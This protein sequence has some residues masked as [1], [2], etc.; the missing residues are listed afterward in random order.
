MLQKSTKQTP[1]EIL[2]KGIEIELEKNND[3]NEATE[4]S[5]ENLLDSSD[6]YNSVA[7]TDELRD[8]NKEDQLRNIE[9]PSDDHDL[10]A[11]E[12]LKVTENLIKGVNL[13]Q[14][15]KSVSFIESISDYAEFSKDVLY[16]HY[17]IIKHNIKKAIALSNNEP[18]FY[19][20][21][22]MLK[23]YLNSLGINE[24]GSSLYMSTDGVVE[25]E[26][27]IADKPFSVED[28]KKI[29]TYKGK[30]FYL[31]NKLKLLGEGSSRIVFKIDNKKVIKLA[32]NSKGLGQNFLEAE[33]GTDKYYADAVAQVFDFDPDFIWIIS[34]YASK[35]SEEKFKEIE[36]YS[37]RTFGVFLTSEKY[38]QEW[39]QAVTPEEYEAFQNSKSPNSFAKVIKQLMDDA[40][41]PVGDLVARSSYGIS[42]RNGKPAVILIDYGLDDNVYK[43]YYSKIKEYVIREMRMYLK[44]SEPVFE[45]KMTYMPNSTSVE[46]KRNCK[47]AGKSDGTSDACNQGDIS[48]L[49]LRPIRE[50]SD[51]EYKKWKRENVTY[52]G[53]SD[54]AVN[55]ENNGMA[56]LGRGL[57]SVPASNKSMARKYGKLVMLVNAK[58]KNPKVFNTL[59]D[60][61]IWFQN[62]IVFPISKAKGKTYPDSRDVNS[63]SE[64]MMK[65]GYDGVIIKGREMVNYKPE[66]VRY[67]YNERQLEMYY[68]HY[69]APNSNNINEAI[70]INDINDLPF[71]QEIENL[72][73]KLYSVGGAVRDEF[74]GKDS[75]DLDVLITGIS[76]E[77][78]EKLL[79]KYGRVNAVG[80]SFGILKF[81]PEGS[82]E[83]IDIAIP[84]TERATGK[85]GHKGFEIASDHSLPIEKDLERRDFTINAIAKSAS[86]DI[87]DPYGGQEDLKNKIIRVVNPK[88]FS[89]DPLR[90]LRAVQFAA[91]FEGFMIEE[92]T[93]ELIKQNAHRIK[94]I[95]AERILTELDKIVKKGDV[96]YGADLLR[97]TGLYEQIFGAKSPEGFE[98]HWDL[99]AWNEVKTMGEYIY[100]LASPV[101]E[102]PA[103]FYKNILKGD[104]STYKEI[105]A[106]QTGFN[107]VTNNP[108]K[109]RIVAHNMY[110]I[111]PASLNSKIL[112][113][114]L[115]MATEELKTGKYP[116]SYK[117]LV[118]TG[119][120]LLN[121]GMSGKKLGDALKSMLISVYSDKVKNNKNDLLNIIN[122]T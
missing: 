14:I 58:P 13:S 92:K 94:E 23:N 67:F 83:E 109:N 88:A 100:L 65:L 26:N 85:G 50:N 76:L 1:K 24:N 119:N 61:E 74:L 28:L 117:D 11:I 45:R 32:K 19:E 106:L 105:L 111:Y 33:I 90:M 57:Y 48:N 21:L 53:I 18:M 44:D 113:K 102:N 98:D 107:N 15:K 89:D 115:L 49:K 25:N 78:L 54:N 93:M 4:L 72:G 69:V 22:M 29:K 47:L 63:I 95:P 80:K 27:K 5:L 73:G 39:K 2:L 10:W 79:S 51:L 66:N 68:D 81:K 46:V 103:E 118:I 75:K 101:Q 87:V 82:S 30:I 52:R 97:E 77:N 84:R 35:I 91:R 99:N 116:K 34:E 104:I 108:I 38:N 16:K 8:M 17:S 9:P 42:I 110:T 59:N 20:K 86:G 60:W 3:I 12:P 36:G 56:I 71:K 31:K 40:D 64:K 43:S 7:P 37:F 96:L 41:M 6:Y 114:K 122:T 112:P 121:M 55:G 70:S 62:N 120:D